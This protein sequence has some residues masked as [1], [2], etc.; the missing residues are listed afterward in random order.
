M[1]QKTFI[2]ISGWIFGVIALVHA[3][4][5]VFGWVATINDFVVPVWLSGVVVVIAGYLAYQGKKLVAAYL[6]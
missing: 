4:R 1:E 6:Q 2:K 3:V 5:L